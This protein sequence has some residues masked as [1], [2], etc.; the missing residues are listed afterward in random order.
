MEIDPG[1]LQL[2][3][4]YKP[5]EGVGI[6]HVALTPEHFQAWE[7]VLLLR[8][9]VAN[10]ELDGYREWKAADAGIFGEPWH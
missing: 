9:E 7:P 3:S 4:I 8:G 5:E 2:G 6:G 10:D 1:E